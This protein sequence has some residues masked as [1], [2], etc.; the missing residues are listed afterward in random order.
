MK[1]MFRALKVHNYRLWV[2]GALVSNIGTWMQRVAQDWL[3]LTILTNHSGTAVGITTGLQFLPIIFIGPFAGL[4]GDRVSKR[5]ILLCTQTAMGLCALT[6]G[7]LVV[8]NAVQLW[9]VFT[10]ALLLGVA[11]A[12]DA[13]SRQAFVSEVVEQRDVPNAV[14]LN[15]ASFNLARLAGP[16][17][18]GLLIA[19]FGTGTAFLLNAA[20]FLAVLISLLRMRTDELHTSARAPRGKGQIREGLVYIRQRPDLMMIMVLVGVVATFGMNFQITNA[21]MATEVFHLGPGEYGLLGSVMAVGTLAAALLAARRQGT[22][23]RYVIGG[24][25]AFAVFV[26]VAALMP[27]Y[28]LYALALIP[29]GLASLTFMNACNTSVQLSTDSVMRGRVL[30]VYMVVLQ[31]GTPIG[32]PLVG[33]IGTVF[34]ARW[35]VGIGAVVALVAGVWALV[36]LNRRN[37]VRLRDQMHS[38]TQ[39]S[40]RRPLRG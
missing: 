10:I 17:V 24:V 22:R 13:P 30:A 19:Y 39:F 5:K 40:F 23:M 21:L 33:W 31:G 38:V 2:G 35:S 36:L 26:A 4:L 29:V 16:G 15:S 18:A 6:L 3:V 11:S 37:D 27:S 34:G 12:I 20:S 14:A 8:T 9:Q 25:L 32:A 7:L 1:E 28:W